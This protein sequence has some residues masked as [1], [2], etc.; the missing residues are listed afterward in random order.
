MTRAATPSTDVGQDI[1]GIYR[2]K[3]IGGYD[4]LVDAHGGIRPQWHAFL[5]ELD[6]LPEKERQSRAVRLDRRVR[7][8]GIAHDIF[9]D[10]NRASQRW[11]LDLAPVIISSS[12]WRNLGRGLVQRARLLDGV[13]GDLYGE[14]RLMR[15]GLIPPELAFADST[16]LRPCQN[17]QR[18]DHLHFYAAD[19]ARGTDGQW[20]VID[21][22]TETLAGLGFSLA[23]RV[24]HTHIAGDIFKRCN[25]LRLADHFQRVQTALTAFSGRENARIALLTP[26]AHH[27]D[28]FSHAYI[29]RYL[30]YLLVEGRDLVTKSGRLFLKTL[31]GLKDIDLVLRCADGRLIDPLE[32]DPGGFEGPAGLVRVNR[33]APNLVVNAIGSGIAQNRGLGACL[34][35]LAHDLLGEELELPDAPRRWL[36]DAANRAHVLANL[37][38]FVIRK[39]Q[40]GTGRPGQAALGYDPSRISAD[41]REILEREIELHGATLVAEEKIGFSTAPALTNAGLVPKP[42]AVRCFVARTADG[43]RAMPGGLAMTVNPGRAVALSAPDGHTRDVWILADGEQAPHISLWRSTME[44]ARVERTQRLIQSRVADDL[45]WLGRYCER[46]DWTM[47]VMRGALRRV[48]E[49][50][51]P[52]TG[53]RAAHKC[54]AVLMSVPEEGKDKSAPAEIEDLLAS[55]VKG[56]TAPRTLERTCGHLHRVAHLTRDRL[57]LEAWQTLSKFGAGDAWSQA[58]AQAAPSTMLDLLDEGLASLSAFNGLM[59]ENMTR[60]F[61]WAFLDMGRRLERAYNL[62]EA[63]LTLFIPRPDEEEEQSSLQL[64][65]ELADSFITYRSRYRLDPMLPLVLDLL[66]LDETNP[67]SL[68]FQLA[69]LSRHMESLPDANRGRGLSEA[70]RILLALSTSIRL[71]DVEVMSAETNGAGLSELLRQQLRLLPEFTSAL[72][73]QYFNLIDETPH[74]VQTRSNLPP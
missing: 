17:L 31:E 38:A 72:S 15:E 19:L 32:L 48:A 65:L 36:G 9:A 40:E 58:M 59:H 28:Y 1:L 33:K 43:Y 50:N 70:R 66:L 39:T 13:I 56:G 45:F 64:L 22:H 7:E 20:R 42:F 27:A 21:S 74:R 26:G 3:L 5:A 61:G 14:Q 34:P 67:R 49:N 71:A 63:I 54:L 2:S 47:R 29:A 11:Q 68:A 51:G 25:V 24:V 53:R 62:S 16:Y 8:T 12:E 52:A 4:E 69:A 73:R 30:G 55:L 37:E 60:N 18:S 6:A 41:E 57:S 10:P 46:S 23:N 44:T 35:A